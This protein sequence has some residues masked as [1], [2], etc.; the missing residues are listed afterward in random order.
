MSTWG[1]VRGYEWAQESYTYESRSAALQNGY[2]VD[3][4]KGTACNCCF[5][6]II[7]AIGREA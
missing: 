5:P 1:D 2:M 3:D 4:D 7:K 6:R